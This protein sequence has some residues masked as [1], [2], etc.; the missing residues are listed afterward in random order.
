MRGRV[1]G[2]GFRYFAREQARAMGVSGWV[3]NLPGGDVEVEA[4]GPRETLDRY[5]TMLQTGHPHANVTE[6]G[7]TELK[8]RDAST[9]FEIR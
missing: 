5:L 4:E 1:Q 8:P 7:R 3:R 2:I 6:V 9:S